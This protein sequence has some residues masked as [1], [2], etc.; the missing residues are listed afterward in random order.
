MWQSLKAIGQTARREVRL[1]QRIARHP[2]PFLA[3]A[4]LGLAVGYPILPFD[5]IP[6]SSLLLS[7]L[8]IS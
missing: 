3:K 4:F 8:M 6:T 7:I 5:L 2:R 1:Y